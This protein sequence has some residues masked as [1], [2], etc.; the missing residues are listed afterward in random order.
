MSIVRILLSASLPYSTQTVPDGETALEVIDQQ[1][2]HLV[3]TE[4]V[5]PGIDGLEVLD[6]ARN[7]CPPVPSIVVTSHI[8][9]FEEAARS[10][11]ALAFFKK[12]CDSHD[13]LGA[14][15]RVIQFQSRANRACLALSN[16]IQATASEGIDY[17]LAAASDREKGNFYFVGG[18]LVHAACGEQTGEEAAHHMLNW[19][20][21][22]YKLYPLNSDQGVPRTIFKNVQGLLLDHAV[23]SDE[24]RGCGV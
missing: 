19:C 16:L 15:G 13:L 2:F 11:G 7:A 18:S 20:L 9:A 23:Q 22:G 17:R 24:C 5:L 10:L 6:A 4:L 12:P 8:G 21:A 3:I 1:M 14:I